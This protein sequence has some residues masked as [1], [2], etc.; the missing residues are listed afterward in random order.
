M[1]HPFFAGTDWQA[2]LNKQVTPPFRPSFNILESAK[3][4]RGWSDKDK[5]KLLSVAISPSDQARFRG[6]PFVS[7]K[8]V[9]KEIIQNMA[10]R[11]YVGGISTQ[12]K[13]ASPSPCPSRDAISRPSTGMS[14]SGSQGQNSSASSSTPPRHLMQSSSLRKVTE[15]PSS[16]VLKRAGTGLSG[17]GGFLTR[18]RSQPSS[19]GSVPQQ[20]HQFLPSS[21]S[22]IGLFGSGS[23]GSMPPQAPSPT[24]IAVGGDPLN[25]SGH[26]GAL[27]RPSS[28][29]AALRTAS[30]SAYPM[31]ASGAPVRPIT[32]DQSSSIGSSKDGKCSLM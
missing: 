12:E 1:N 31:P 14:T 8:A 5:A 11:E 7:Q 6:V 16:P 30:G 20:N 2:I 32:R 28:S 4:V 13:A 23:S 18:G 25:R 3:P 22:P 26:A 29:T 9:Y 27:N 10:L 19:L 24:A 21:P 17:F 15:V